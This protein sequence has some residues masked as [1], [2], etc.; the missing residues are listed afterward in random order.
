MLLPTRWPRRRHLTTIILP[1]LLFSIQTSAED[2]LFSTA[3]SQRV[4]D[5]F[6]NPP[7][8]TCPVVQDGS[9]YDTFPWTYNPPCVNAVIPN[10][11]GLGIHQTFCAYTNTYYNNGRGI[12]FVVS[13]EVAASIT[14]ETFS[15]G[16]GGLEGMVGEEMGMWE[17][18][19]AGSGKGKGLF[20]TNDVAGIFAGEKVIVQ[21]PALFVDKALMGTPSTARRQ[22]VLAKAVEQLPETT[23]KM[24]RILHANRDGSVEDVVTTNGVSVEW[25]WVDENPKLFALIPEV[26]RINHA[27][28]PNTSWRFDD[29]TLSFEIFAL[30]DIKPGEEITRSYGFERQPHAQRL[31]S[32]RENHGFTCA[33]RLCTANATTI[34]AS[35]RRL[36]QI[37]DLKAVLPTSQSDIPQL[38]G[39]LPDLIS[40]LE[41][42]ELVDELQLY[43]EILA[44]TWSSFG[45]ED[46]ARY[47]A[48]R[49][50][51]HWAVMAGRESWEAKRC[52][53]MEK[54]VKGHSTWMSW[55]GEDPWE[56]VGEGHPWDEKDHAH[57]HD[58]E[59]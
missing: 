46:R 13:P 10:K 37:A 22:F 28:R 33:C 19:K 39:L 30:R 3:S 26:A 2:I 27:C 36:T 58:H 5:P 59:H 38:I 24:V 47:W 52:A 21:T 43:E 48:G 29:Y 53:D 23:R 34:E 12:S 51:Q 55:D 11:N 25:P 50:S 7:P 45:I 32:L 40:L 14:S 4:Q 20:A 31:E 41:E 49:A 56:G 9:T 8:S 42:E 54:D 18:D 17:I 15:L 57:E 35:N 6:L 44:Y 16:V 1:T